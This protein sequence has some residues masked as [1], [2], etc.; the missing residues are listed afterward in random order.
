MKRRIVTIAVVFVLAM[1]ALWFGGGNANEASA[2]TAPSCRALDIVAIWPRSLAV[3]LLIGS[4][5]PGATR[6]TIELTT[7]SEIA[8]YSLPAIPFGDVAGGYRSA[9]IALVAPVGNVLSAVLR[10]M[11]ATA[12]CAKTT[13][14][15]RFPDTSSV[16]G[17]FEPSG[18]DLEFQK[19]VAVEAQGPDRAVAVTT[20]NAATFDCKVAHRDARATHFVQPE[21]SSHARELGQVGTARVK[22]SLSASGA[23]QS[24]SIYKSSGYPDLDEASLA[25]AKASTYAP[26]VEQCFS[27][28]GAYLF[29]ADFRG[30]KSQGTN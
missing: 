1:P 11:A 16:Y 2:Q 3:W 30:V 23:V 26:E 21:Y 20:R 12:T 24:I 5:Q 8:V 15:V 6:A 10:P 22:V 25:A 28:D 27:V 7:E 17:P 19:T 9:P 29:R 13:R 4:D 14:I 18:G